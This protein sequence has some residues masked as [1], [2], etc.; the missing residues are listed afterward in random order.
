MKEREREREQFAITTLNA[1]TL[2]T[3]TLKIHAFIDRQK[4]F[5]VAS[6]IVEMRT[7]TK[8]E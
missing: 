7:M 2:S 3:P 6:L 4:I 1:H 5:S 8:S